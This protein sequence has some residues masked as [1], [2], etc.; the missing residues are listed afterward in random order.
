[1]SLKSHWFAICTE[2]KDADM[3]S[4]HLQWPRAGDT[5]KGGYMGVFTGHTDSGQGSPGHANGLQRLRYTL[6]HIQGVCGN[7]KD[8][9][10]HFVWKVL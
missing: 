9:W 1:M 5:N 3:L 2:T 4:Q 6:G 10:V 7:K 8:R